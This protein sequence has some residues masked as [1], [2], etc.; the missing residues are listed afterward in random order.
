MTY[1]RA[2]YGVQV[3]VVHGGTPRPHDSAVYEP[4]QTQDEQEQDQY[5][6][7][8]VEVRNNLGHRLSVYRQARS[9][10]WAKFLE[11]PGTDT[12][13]GSRERKSGHVEISGVRRAKY[14]S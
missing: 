10:L 6:E 5:I 7:R 1:H 4:L 8:L 13:I 9:Y 3:L 11:L 14:S 12:V 2:G